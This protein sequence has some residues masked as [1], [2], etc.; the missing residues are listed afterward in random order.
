M[1]YLDKDFYLFVLTCWWFAKLFESVRLCLLRSLRSFKLLVLKICSLHHTPFLSL[2]SDDINV[3]PFD[4]VLHVLKALFTFFNLFPSM[5]LLTFY[6]LYLSS[7]NLSFV[8]SILW[9]NSF[10]KFLK[11]LLIFFSSSLH[12]YLFPDT[13]YLFIHFNSV[14]PYLLEYFIV[15]SFKSL[16]NNPNTCVIFSIGISCLYLCEFRFSWLCILWVI[17]DYIL[18]VLNIMVWDSILL[19]NADTFVL[20]GS[21]AGWVQVANSYQSSEVVVLMMALFTR[22]L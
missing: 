12:I 9:L 8:I 14:C 5:L 6:H 22:P 21:W 17:L 20:S 16:S 10:S 3:R 13:F 2:D 19:E 4:I 18:D 15:I 11:T 7:L 1:I